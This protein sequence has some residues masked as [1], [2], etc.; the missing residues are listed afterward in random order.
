MNYIR[1]LIHYLLY[2]FFQFL[3]LLFNFCY[4]IWDFFCSFKK[5][6]CLL[7][8]FLFFSFINSLRNCISFTS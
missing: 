1:N 5:L 2:F 7:F 8:I 3:S 4:F 6:I